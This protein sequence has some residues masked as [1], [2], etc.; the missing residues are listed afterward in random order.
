[1]ASS[2]L[3]DILTQK[4][5]EVQTHQALLVLGLQNDFLLQDGKLP[6]DTRSGFLSRIKKLIPIFRENAGDVIWVRT[7]FEADR[8][9]NDPSGEGDTVILDIEPGQPSAIDE[10]AEVAAPS[11]PTEPSKSRS[12][13]HAKRALDLLKK[14]SSRKLSVTKEVEEPQLPVADDELFLSKLRKDGP[15]F[16]PTTTGAHMHEIVHSLI[17]KS[18]DILTNTSHY[19]AFNSTTLLLTMRT[20]LVTDLYICGCLSNISVFA[21]ALDAAKHGLN[22]TI[23]SDCLGYRSLTR[24]EEAVKQLKELLGAF[25]VTSEELLDDLAVPLDEAEYTQEMSPTQQADL[26]SIM[27]SLSV[28]KEER[29][30]REEKKAK[31]TQ[32]KR[33][34]GNNNTR[35]VSKSEL[36]KMIDARK[37]MAEE[38]EAVGKP[39]TDTAQ[40]REARDESP[41]QAD[42]PSASHDDKPG[43]QQKSVK[44][45]KSRIRM[46]QRSGPDSENDKKRPATSE[47]PPPPLPDLSG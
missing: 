13:R 42:S 29:E 27:D 40:A 19:S 15:C 8:A 16:L 22:V 37:E 35:Q 3:R 34:G 2:F 26:Q 33:S 12:N 21:T 7:I 46:R 18:A 44:Q 5:P 4:Q 11:S 30:R 28:R 41:Q 25:E 31:S 23:I 9:A 10:D 43:L 6:I 17:D 20:K 24:H 14:V 32:G 45:R 1:M 36:R 39:A 38:K 47:G